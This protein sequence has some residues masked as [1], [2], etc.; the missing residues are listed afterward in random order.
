VKCMLIC[1]LSI[2]TEM[3]MGNGDGDSCMR[4]WMGIGDGDDLETTLCPKKTAL[5]LHTIDSTHINRFR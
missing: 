5:M 1:Y 4:G 3:G 2:V